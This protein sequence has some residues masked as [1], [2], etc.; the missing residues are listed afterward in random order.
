MN[1][2]VRF[3]PLIAAIVIA[4]TAL[5]LAA[6]DHANVDQEVR[7]QVDAFID[8]HASALQGP[9]GEQ[10]PKGEPGTPGDQGP[11]G[12][13]GMTGPTGMT[14][15]EGPAGPPGRSG[16]TGQSG[17]VRPEDQLGSGLSLCGKMYAYECR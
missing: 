6:Y 1:R 17:A 11:Q 9:Q 2:L 7:T 12:E 15:P 8:D 10:G 16:A 3:G 14:G 5:G 4:T 13:P